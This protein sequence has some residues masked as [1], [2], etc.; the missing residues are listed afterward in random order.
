MV[1]SRLIFGAT[2]ISMLGFFAIDTV[3][4]TPITLRRQV[5]MAL[6]MLFPQLRGLIAAA[7][8]MR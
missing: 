5:K 7:Q 2:P 3:T 4:K 6:T 1:V 8:Q